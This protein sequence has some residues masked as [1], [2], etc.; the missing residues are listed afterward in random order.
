MTDTTAETA[1]PGP[2]QGEPAD[3]VVQVQMEQP[4]AAPQLPSA[5][6]HPAA[7]VKVTRKKLAVPLAEVDEGQAAQRADGATRTETEAGPVQM[8]VVTNAPREIEELEFP[9]GLKITRV[10]Y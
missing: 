7:Q 8:A 3:D 6:Q 9:A 2:V 10:R 1:A 5:P 4:A